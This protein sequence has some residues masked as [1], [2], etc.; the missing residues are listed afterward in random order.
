MTMLKTVGTINET[1][2][3]AGLNIKLY[4]YVAVLISQLSY[5]CKIQDCKLANMLPS[6][7]M[8]VPCTL[9]R[10]QRLLNDRSMIS[11]ML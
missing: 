3:K 10:H 8:I 5:L 4:G 1:P 11:L 6:N 7:T 9:V 2:S